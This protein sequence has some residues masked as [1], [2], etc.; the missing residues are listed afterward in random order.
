MRSALTL[1]LLFG[2]AHGAEL[3]KLTLK[4][5]ID[6]A[7]TNN[8]RVLVQVQELARAQ[9]QVAQVRAA[10]L[11]SVTG[12]ATYTRSP[13]PAMAAAAGF[14]TPD[15]VGANLTAVVPLLAPR[16][17]VQWSQQKGSA[18]VAALDVGDV[19]R[20]VAIGVSTAFLQIL[21]RRREVELDERARDT[22]RA[23][24]SYT[25]TRLVGGVGSRLD[26]VRARQELE[27]DEQLVVSARLALQQAQETLGLLVA[28][29]GPV[30]AGDEPWLTPVDAGQALAEAPR[31]RADLLAL[32]ARRLLTRRIVHDDWA[33]YM[34]SLTA[35]FSGPIYSWPSTVFTQT[36]SW[37]FQLALTVP[38]YD[39]GLR[40]GLARERRA[41]W[42]EAK[43]DQDTALRQLRSDLRFD[44]EAVRRTE[45][46]MGRA[47]AAAKLAHEAVQIADLAYRAG[48][49][50]NLEL[51][52]AE[53]RA[54]DADTAAAIAEDAARQARLDLLFAAGRL[55]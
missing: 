29:E 35:S 42:H 17:W 53:R 40:Y 54:R 4:Q 8:P 1:V 38:I 47:H 18:R 5:A 51:I 37:Q 41:L 28:A 19:K 7:L 45:E 22:A 55:P 15:N 36:W 2:V 13:V 16:R 3:P 43:I 25:H 33:D 46:A 34:P 6:R 24:A 32:D 39:G 23:H 26:D 10:A 30:D 48:A 12:N 52:D 14:A 9:A 20:Q 27:T 11:P 31:L 44:D 21:T 49:T 50:T